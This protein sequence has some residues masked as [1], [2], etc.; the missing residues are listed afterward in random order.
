MEYGGK[1]LSATFIRIY[2]RNAD[3]RVEDGQHDCDLTNFA[4][5]VPQIGDQILA[6]GVLQ[7]RDRADP[8]NREIWTVVGRLFNPKDNEA[9]VA[10]IVETRQPA[11]SEHSLLPGH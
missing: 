4:G 9:Y 2:F 6:S 3:G 11:P 7:G 10:L 5:V 8:A 1:N